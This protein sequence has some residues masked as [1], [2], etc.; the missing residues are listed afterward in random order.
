MTN[1]TTDLAARFEAKSDLA[2]AIAAEIMGLKWTR[3]LYGP[4]DEAT[5]AETD[6]RHGSIQEAVEKV[7]AEARDMARAGAAGGAA[8]LQSVT[9][10]LAEQERAARGRADDCRP[11]SDQE[12]WH[13]AQAAAYEAAHAYAAVRP[14]LA[15]A[16]PPTAQQGEKQRRDEDGFV[17]EYDP[18]CKPETDT[19]TICWDGGARW[20]IVDR[21]GLITAGQSPADDRPVQQTTWQALMSP[22]PAQQG[23]SSPPL[24]AERVDLGELTE[25]IAQV[26]YQAHPDISFSGD[27]AHVVKWHQAVEVRRVRSRKAAARIIAIVPASLPV[28]TGSADE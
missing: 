18:G 3:P 1:P 4:D 13:R 27:G 19:Y 5:E 26:I 20:L 6:R 12:H 17:C 16:P 14:A 28:G 7:I 23:S 8:A 10:W 24:T 9:A 25:K 22:P 21:H 2:S 15:A 11:S